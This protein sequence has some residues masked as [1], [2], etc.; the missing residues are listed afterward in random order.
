M[1]GNTAPRRSIRN[2]AVAA[3]LAAML[4]APLYFATP[5]TEAQAALP[6]CP[7]GVYLEDANGRVVVYDFSCTKRQ[8]V[9][10][11][12]AGALDAVGSIETH[13]QGL[14]PTV[15]YAPNASRAWAT[16]GAVTND[17]VSD[18]ASLTPEEADAAERF[19]QGALN[20]SVGRY[21]GDVTWTFAENASGDGFRLELSPGLGWYLNLQRTPTQPQALYGTSETALS[22]LWTPDPAEHLSF[23]A[24]CGTATWGPVDVLRG[25]STWNEMD[26]FGRPG[27]L[28]TDVL[29]SDAPT[30]P[31]GRF[32]LDRLSLDGIG[33][34]EGTCQEEIS[35]RAEWD[36]LFVFEARAKTPE[37][38]VT[39]MTA[40]GYGPSN[41]IAE[42]EQT[43]QGEAFTVGTYESTRPWFKWRPD[44][45]SS[46]QDHTAEFTTKVFYAPLFPVQWACGFMDATGDVGC[47]GTG[48]QIDATFWDAVGDSL[49]TVRP[50]IGAAVG[51]VAPPGG[52]T[53]SSF[54]TGSVTDLGLVSVRMA[55]IS[56]DGR[57]LRV[58]VPSV[59]F[60]S[61][62]LEDF[63]ETTSWQMTGLWHKD[64]LCSAPPTASKYLGY[65][66]TGL[67]EYT[68]YD[69]Y[70]AA[71]ANMGTATRVF[72]LSDVDSAKLSMLHRFEV[73]NTAY[74]SYDAMSVQVRG[75]ANSL[76]ASLESW[77]TL[78]EWDSSDHMTNEWIA[79]TLDLS[80]EAG[81]AYV[82]VRLVFD[83]G[84]NIANAHPGWLV[85][86][87]ILTTDSAPSGGGGGGG[88]GGA[89]MTTTMYMM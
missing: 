38:L 4:A 82:A 42:L 46:A 74:G 52:P 21:K 5:P 16:A 80:A 69:T 61:L 65:H 6:A 34:P 50:H 12:H 59:S 67:C 83:T 49:E 40:P 19:V 48:Q 26:L 84:D 22:S 53:T 85:D 2:A 60:S 37:G 89:E 58:G 20:A 17:F 36:L 56:T 7:D 66:R 29:E 8:S 64:D 57:S 81:N 44:W 51:V 63:D 11:E 88:G 10:Y 87:M 71:T 45:L 31:Y 9:S 18:L 25:S 14:D 68:T 32:R 76:L 86:H 33:W 1:N 54:A 27:A 35:V 70:G 62:A 28:E 23:T 75:A 43:A 78:A 55:G 30:G 39:E 77:T 79:E 41:V 13:V 15:G 3:L 73:E 24:T 47:S 72:D